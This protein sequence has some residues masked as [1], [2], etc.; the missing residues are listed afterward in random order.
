MKWL[1][2]SV[3]TTSEFADLVSMTLL[4]N[5]SEGVNIN[6]PNEYLESLK[7]NANW[8]YPLE[9]MPEI[10][11]NKV[12]VTGFFETTYKIGNIKKDLDFL[13]KNTPFKTGSLELSSKEIDS[14]DWENV[15]K[16]FYTPIEVGEVVIMPKWLDTDIQD[17]FKILMDPGL[18]FGT[19]NHET[20]KLCIEL[21]QEF[22][23]NSMEVADVG[24]GSGILGITA[25]KLGAKNC[26]FI[27]FD[28]NA[29][30]ATK[31]NAS[32]NDVLD[33][34]IVLK[35]D[36][37]TV[38]EKNKKFDIILAN[39]TADLL[40]RLEEQLSQFLDTGGVVIASGILEGYQ[41]SVI[42]KYAKDFTISKALQAG[43]WHALI[44]KKI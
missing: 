17:R 12:I 29:I 2:V 39:L 38:V 23:L 30:S 19:G 10:K 18:A 25:L 9:S 36:L 6:D 24:C 42:Q 43:E 11:D 32:D 4:D 44:C 8:D 35:G 5:G 27:D 21:M 20:T 16:K 33:N 37:M 34:A 26:T 13:A 28:E 31:I 7:S 15:W 3:I 41:D 1:E 14:Q 22:D 40:N